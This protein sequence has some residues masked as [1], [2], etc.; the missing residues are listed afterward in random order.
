MTIRI[1]L[2]NVHSSYNAGDTALTQAAI[3]QL[4][5]NFP[6][7]QISLVANDPESIIGTEPMF[8]SFYKWVSLTGKRQFSRFLR[9][10][11]TSLFSIYSYRVFKSPMLFLIPKGLRETVM[12]YLKSDIVVS[13]PGGYLFSYGKGRALIVLFFSIIFPILAGKPVYLFPQSFGPLK[14]QY[15]YWLAR[16]I[17]A[18]TRCNMAREPVSLRYLEACNAPKERSY[19]L[20]DMAFAY[21]SASQPEARAWLTKQK[22]L[23]AGDCPLFGLTV[24]DWAAQYPGFQYQREYESA[25]ASLIKYYINKYHGKVIFYPQCWGPTPFEDDR[26]P[27]KRIAALVEEFEDSILVVEQPVMPRL[28]KSIYAEM[29]IFLGTRMHSNIF[30]L[31]GGVPVIAIGYLHKTQGI[32]AQVG[33]EEWVIDIQEMIAPYLISKFDK[34]W[35]ARVAMHSHLEK[36]M[37]RLAREARQAGEILASDYTKYRGLFSE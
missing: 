16:W 24:I 12:A 18:R 28:L 6:N 23:P 36:K 26:I 13:T 1:L 10:V 3:D 30:T 21:E 9:L 27:A 8:L 5:A 20:P 34:L 25:I 4:Y 32:A 2:I 15:E 31:S 22:I 35:N 33:I 37:P 17:L 29:D 11:V 7:C 14:Y 19:L